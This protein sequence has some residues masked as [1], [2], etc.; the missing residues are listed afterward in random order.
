MLIEISRFFSILIMKTLFFQHLL[1]IFGFSSTSCIER[2]I[3]NEKQNLLEFC[4]SSTLVSFET[5]CEASA[6]LKR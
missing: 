2:Y 4:V 3:E 1:Y 6:E 5:V